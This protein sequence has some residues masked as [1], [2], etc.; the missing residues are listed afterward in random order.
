MIVLF[1]G[2]ALGFAATKA[3][4]FNAES[5]LHLSN[6][7]LC[8]ANPCTALYSVLGTQQ[9]LSPREVLL[10]SAIALVFYLVMILA[11]RLTP[12]L[13]RTA[14]EERGVYQF[15]TIFSNVGFMG[16]PVVRAVYGDGAMFHATIF[17]VF[18]QLLAYTYGIHLISTRREDARLSWRVLARPMVI[19]SFIA[20]ALYFTDAAQVL[21]AHWAGQILVRTLGF[22]DGITSPLCMVIIG[23]SLGLVPL[24]RVF[25]NGRL[26]AL[27]AFKQLVLPVAMYL[28]LRPFV[29]NELILGICVI[30]TAMPIAAL[31]NLFCAKYGGPCDTAASGVFLSTL[32]SVPAIPLLMLVLFH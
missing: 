6:L 29:A 19:A 25:T 22:V 31:T 4:L 27:V 11:A 2:S 14:P 28:I 30:M 24:K 15:M 13:L 26:Y 1:A 9:L 23:I 32:F 20:Y 5:R 7:A 18:F 16:Y 17:N 3:G 8:V 21:A 10:L 12:R